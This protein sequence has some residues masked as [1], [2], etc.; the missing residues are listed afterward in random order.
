MKSNPA[1]VFLIVA[2]ASGPSTARYVEEI[3]DTGG[4]EGIWIAVIAFALSVYVRDEFKKSRES[5]AKALGISA[6]MVAVIVVFPAVGIV[7]GGLL[8]LCFV[9]AMFKKFG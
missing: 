6:L 4:N 9:V 2:A 8:F 3:S 7:A 1:L 5:G